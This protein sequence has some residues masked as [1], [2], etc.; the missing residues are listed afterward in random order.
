MEININKEYVL[1]TAQEIL[2]FNSPTGFCFE[3]MDLIEEK[4]HSLGY[5]FERTNKGCGVI[6]IDGK[7][8]EKVIGL[9]S[10]VDTLGAMV[11]SITSKGTLKF[12]LLGGPIVPTLDSEYCTIRTRD[13]KKYTGTFLSE[14]AAIHV[15]EDASTKKRTPENMEIRI[16]EVV[17]N[18]DDVKALGIEAGDFVFIDPKTTIT[19][20]G[21]IK[22][23]FIDDKGSVTCL[24]SILELFKREHIVPSYKTKFF[25]STYEEVGHGSSYIPQ[26]I[27]ELLSV[28]MGCIGDDLNCS[29]YDVSICAKDSGGP[30]DY[31]M[32]TDLVNLA[33]E[34][35]LSY[36]I[37]IY[38]RYGSDVGAALTAGNNIRGALIGP[39]VHASH[40]MERTHYSAL[41][42]TMKL[43][44]LY[45]T[46]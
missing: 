44:Y 42:N 13:G 19:E 14:S 36:A 31:N 22:S 35:G 20:S 18:K 23:R 38:P 45:L 28:D 3:I 40:G 9:S 46:K 16:D 39:G 7:S 30:Y 33:K 43:I 6:T 34:N 10:H 27:T 11:R 24:L 32:T 1:N 2:K 21:F 29:E 17:K 15:Y 5:K 41:E 8:D 25:I 4:V 37:D 26:D 12:T